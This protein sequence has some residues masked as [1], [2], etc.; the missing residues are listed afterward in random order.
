[1]SSST[2]VAQ[3]NIAVQVQNQNNADSGDSTI[4]GCLLE[5]VSIALEWQSSGGLRF[6]NNKINGSAMLHG[7]FVNLAAG[8]TTADIFIQN[9]S[10]EGI[11]TTSGTGITFVRQGSTGALG[12]VFITGN[13]LSGQFCLLVPTDANGTVWINN[14][15]ITDNICVNPTQCAFSIDTV[16]GLVLSN[17]FIQPG[18]S[19]ITPI[20]I[21]PTGFSSTNSVVGPNPR[22]T[23]TNPSNTGACTVIL[24][25]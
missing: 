11:S 21:G 19:A 3:G 5:S 2:I 22:L 24:P 4:F 10:I 7:I 20:A 15:V 14:M 16:Q 17:N 8:A 18:S 9:N 23:A 6:N 25:T 12:T 1:L 13:E